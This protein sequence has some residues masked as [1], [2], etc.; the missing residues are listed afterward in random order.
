[1]INIST[2]ASQK[3]HALNRE[4]QGED[5]YV[6]TLISSISA[7]KSKLLLWKSNLNKKTLT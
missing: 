2:D 4:L 7:F 1:V 5:K 6:S 3:L